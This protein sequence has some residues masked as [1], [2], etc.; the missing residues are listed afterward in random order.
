MPPKKKQQ[1]VRSS[2]ET[3]NTSDDIG[4]STA[5]KSQT[6]KRGRGGSETEYENNLITENLNNKELPE[7]KN[8]PTSIVLHD[9]PKLFP[10][11]RCSSLFAPTMCFEGH[12][13]AVYTCAFDPTGQTLAT[14]GMDRSI[15]LWDVRGSKSN[16]FNVL[17]GHKNAVLQ[18]R[19]MAPGDVSSPPLLA[20]CSA[21]KTVS[22]WDAN[23]GHR[24]RK[25]EEHT[26]IVNCLD[27]AKHA[28]TI[29]ASGSDDCTAT[30]WDTR[31]EEPVCTLF[32]D[33]QVTS[34]AVSAD[35]GTVYT[36]GIDNIIRLW[37][38]RKGEPEEPYLCLSGHTDTIT[39]LSL[40]PDGHSLLSNAMD[41]SLRVWNVRPYVPGMQTSNTMEQGELR[42]THLFHGHTHGAEKALLRC[43]WSA[44]G[45]LVA[46]GSADRSVHIWDAETCEPK[47]RLPG[48]TGSVNEIAFHHS[49]PI[50]AS[51]ST[52]K[53]IWLGELQ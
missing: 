8:E 52:D 32:H 12:T 6:K 36:G 45:T 7:T 19:W 20:S 34:I 41:A 42:C 23:K 9:N 37:D 28:S 50:V 44:D 53:T 5:S 3:S 51:C 39:G 15:Y 29:L 21:D 27:T 35:A 14:A 25:M 10:P 49:E 13:G 38:M 31:Q 22:L 16:N 30:V 18:V 46:A 40:S 43:A 33:Y 48:H 24:L 17:K 1:R 47:Y 26:G 2:S 11:G 4:A